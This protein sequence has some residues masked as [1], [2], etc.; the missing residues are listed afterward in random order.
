MKT[1]SAPKGLPYLI[2]NMQGFRTPFYSNEEY[3][4]RL[5]AGV[6]S[7]D[8]GDYDVLCAYN[9]FLGKYDAIIAA[10]KEKYGYED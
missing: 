1:T 6:L 4:A 10:V 7:G 5:L 3:Y 2:S 8:K 9:A